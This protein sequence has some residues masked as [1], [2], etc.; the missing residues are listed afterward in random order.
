[1]LMYIYLSSEAARNDL[2]SGITIN[3]QILVKAFIP[4]LKNVILH[5]WLVYKEFPENR[6]WLENFRKLNLFYF[7]SQI[8]LNGEIYSLCFWKHSRSIISNRPSLYSVWPNNCNLEFIF[9]L[10]ELFTCF[11]SSLT[12]PGLWN[13]WSLPKTIWINY[14]FMSM[15]YSHQILVQFIYY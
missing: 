5:M 13:L 3:H 15:L 9:V 11:N 12:I 8:C 6:C 1:M 4:W 2:T 14:L 10:S 7:I